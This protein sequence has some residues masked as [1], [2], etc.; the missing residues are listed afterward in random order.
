MIS[1]IIDIIDKCGIEV[2][3]ITETKSET[4]ELYFVKK[5]LDIPRKKQLTRYRVD[6]FRDMEKDG[7]K[8][9]AMTNAILA[10]GM[11]DADME[12]RIR[13]AY[14]AANFV[15]NPWFE[16]PEP[17]KEAHLEC[18][19]DLAS[20]SPEEAAMKL[21]DGLFSVDTEKDAFLN[22][23]EIFVTKST[24][25]IVASNGLDVCFDK[26]KAEGEIVAQC[27]T[28]KDVEQFR[29]FEYDTLNIE[30]IKE[31]AL[32]AIRDVR[33]RASSTQ[34]PKGGEYDIILTGEHIGTILEFYGARS[35]ASMIFPGYSQW[36]QDMNVQG[37]DIK[38]EK[39]DLSL[40][41]SDP[42]SSE[43][44]RMIKRELISGGVLKLIHGDARSCY[45]LGM[46][47]TGYYNK[48]S[49]SNG[50]VPY[51]ELCTEGVLEPVSFSDFQ[52]DVMDGHFKGEI[53][54]ALLHH[55]DGTVEYLSGG[56]VNGSLTD[57]Q[58]ALVFSTERYADSSYE[59][60][61]AVKI[62]NVAV[63]GI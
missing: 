34:P 23:V 18:D 39:L 25:R 12:K 16:L 14:F 59:G 57:A 45:Y 27:V 43:G 58:N 40:L 21:A 30:G 46:K 52:M 42:F 20:L 35:S 62:P 3:R 24:T 41:S 60:P 2:W 61:L 33:A 48:V 17:E 36:E 13:D 55:A 49:C 7:K 11:S 22:S 15:G 51:S 53:R 44:I 47:P 32:G 54:L 63:A 19:S 9:R 31:R 56:S 8:L 6:V 1:R 38:G 26:C 29:S 10:P 37:E 50:T 28:P 4:A 5:A